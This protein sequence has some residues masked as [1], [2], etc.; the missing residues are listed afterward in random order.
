M[1]SF[2]SVTRWIARLKAGEH[3]AAQK[4][5]QRYSLRLVHLA[6][7]RLRDAPRRAADEEDVAL[8][9]F[10]SLCRGA[11]AGRFPRLSDRDDLWRLLVVLT[12]RKAANLAKHERR[13]KRGGGRVLAEA[14]LALPSD[15]SEDFEGLEA[16]IGDEPT[17]EFAAQVGEECRRLLDALGDPQLR[18]IA[19]MKLEGYTDEEVAARLGCTDRT[20]RRRLQLIRKLWEKEWSP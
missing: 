12:A 15:G 14:E 18:D 9:A 17:P 16:I 20:V 6:R 13:I 4:L 11:E 10:D 2:G 5:W 3:A 8:G 7:A 1:S 19:T